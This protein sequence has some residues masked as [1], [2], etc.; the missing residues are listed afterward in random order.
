VILTTLYLR[1]RN[2]C[3]TRSFVLSHWRDLRTLWRRFCGALT[4]ARAR[5]LCIYRRRLVWEFGMSYNTQ[6]C[7][8]VKAGSGNGTVCFNI[9]VG[10]DTTV[11]HIIAWFGQSRY[12]VIRSRNETVNRV[13]G[14][15]SVMRRNQRRIQ[16]AT[17]PCPPQSS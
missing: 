6:V 5:E 14:N 16:G 2:L 1:E 12:L 3:L 4:T 11:L 15:I 8:G 9:E 17:G 13:G 10:T 7:T